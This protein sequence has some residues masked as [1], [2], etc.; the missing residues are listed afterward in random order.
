MEERRYLRREGLEMVFCRESSVSYPLHNHVSVFTLGFVLDG[1]IELS[2]DQET[3]VY[4]KQ[5][6]FLI[7]PYAPHS[8]KAKS[9]YTLLS[10]CAGK[11][12]LRHA[13]AEEI[14]SDTAGL[15]RNLLNEPEIVHKIIQKVYSLSLVSRMLPPRKET[16]VS[17]LIAQLEQHPE[18]RYR[19][20]DLAKRAFTSKYQFIRSFKREAGLTPHQFQIQNRIRKAQR[21]LKTPATMTEAALAAGFYD[22]SHFIRHFEKL[23]GQTPG[24]YQKSCKD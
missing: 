21:L 2:T 9:C 6:S 19:L 15:L 14:P 7:L 22:Q 10:L 8:I 12:W 13:E 16:A 3:G 17:P 24:E 1:T 11:E 23:V 4:K 18:E 5:D 20:D